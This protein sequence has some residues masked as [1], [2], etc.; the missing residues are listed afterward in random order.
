MEKVLFTL[1]ESL[2]EYTFLLC[3]KHDVNFITREEIK[4]EQ[5]KKSILDNNLLNVHIFDNESQY[6]IISIEF[7]SNICDGID[8]QFAIATRLNSELKRNGG[9]K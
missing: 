8:F 6:T 7:D 3:S 1:L 4:I 5:I 2:K 9:T